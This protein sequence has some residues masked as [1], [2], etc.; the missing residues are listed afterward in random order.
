MVFR[1]K[2]MARRA[3]K[4][5]RRARARAARVP[6]RNLRANDVAGCSESIVFNGLL[7]TGPSTSVFSSGVKG[8]TFDAYRN[9]D[10][11]LSSFTRAQLISLGYQ[12]FKIK[13]FE[14]TIIPD[15]DTFAPGTA[16]GK[17]VL[18]YMIDKGQSIPFNITNQAL[19]SM[20]AK[21]IML[22]EKTIK[23]RWRPG[24]VLANEIQ[25]STG[26][27]SAQQYMTS[28]WL[29]CNGNTQSLL[30]TSSQVCHQGIKWFAENAGS[31][32]TYT[33]T[34]TAHFLFKK[35]NLPAGQPS[36]VT[37]T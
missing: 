6:R 29:P 8:T 35:P 12:Q 4:N 34:L 33:A 25:T 37:S 19:K 28:P 5:V 18:Y 21:P 36:S 13:Y 27:T 9:T 23:I 32:I 17:P 11:S 31:N 26:T 22:D 3:R 15:A 30:Y 10:I 2:L 1:R 24:V 7:P 14:V 20:G 16:Y